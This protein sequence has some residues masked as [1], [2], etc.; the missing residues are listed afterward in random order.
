M[1]S[2]IFSGFQSEERL[3]QLAFLTEPALRLWMSWTG[4][5]WLAFVSSLLLVEVGERSDVSLV[6]GTI[7]GVLVG[8]AQWLALRGHLPNAARWMVA[9]VVS[10]GALT[11][12]QIGALGWMAPGT[13]N[14]FFRGVLGLLSGGYVGVGLG[15]GQWLAIRTQVNE[16]W[17]WVPLNGGIWAVAIALGWLIGG[18]LRL[19]SNLFVSEVIGLMVAWGAIAALSG[20]GIV[21]MLYQTQS[22]EIFKSKQNTA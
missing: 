16:A 8:L 6:E 13:S 10:W 15:V 7:G 12:F 18:G 11:L 22:S 2:G 19:A 21:G 9:T 4:L 17:R 5:T 14:L 20:I 1:S 3:K